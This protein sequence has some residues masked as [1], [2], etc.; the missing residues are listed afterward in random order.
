MKPAL[1]VGAY[2]SVDKVPED[3]F[4]YLREI[5]GEER[6][7]VALNFSSREQELALPELGSG[8]LAIST[9][10]DRTAETDLT[11]LSLRG[12]EGVVIVLGSKKNLMSDPIERME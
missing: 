1:Q 4:V 2:I 6:I 7:L 12:D 8:Y 10:M 3:C 9:F 5:P 11:R